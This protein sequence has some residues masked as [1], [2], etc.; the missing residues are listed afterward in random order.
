MRPHC[1]AP[2]FYDHSQWQTSL[3]RARGSL[4][5]ANL[6]WGCC[7][8]LLL[9][10]LACLGFLLGGS[11]LFSSSSSSS[12]SSPW[13]RS[14]EEQSNVSKSIEVTPL[15]T[16][17]SPRSLISRFWAPPK[18]GRVFDK[19]RPH[20]KHTSP[21][22]CLC[23]SEYASQPRSF[24]PSAGV[25]FHARL[26]EVKIRR[27]ITFCKASDHGV[28]RPTVLLDFPQNFPNSAASPSSSSR[29]R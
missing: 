27:Q 6:N 10:E 26:C 16:L 3:L 1:L 28:S 21:W 8:L 13:G 15:P 5:A 18:S 19:P 24:P 12:S 2:S 22:V 11:L 7:D 25:N 9:G 4:S 17:T 29:S 23:A 14:E 20:A